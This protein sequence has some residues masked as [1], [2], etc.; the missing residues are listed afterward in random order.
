MANKTVGFLGTKVSPETKEY[1]DRLRKE[2][3]LPLSYLFLMGLAKMLPELDPEKDIESIPEIKR[4][5][6]H[7]QIWNV[8]KGEN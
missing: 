6:N 3:G 5:E 2:K 8:L 4:L 7:A 1:F